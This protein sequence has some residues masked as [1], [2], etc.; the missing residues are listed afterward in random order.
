MGCGASKKNSN[1]VQEPAP[2]SP[3]IKE[4]QPSNQPTPQSP[5][6]LAVSPQQASVRGRSPSLHSQ[7]SA[8]ENLSNSIGRRTPCL[9]N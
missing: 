2:N 4:I 7:V 3:S 9:Y 8:K 1:M 5:P 6:L